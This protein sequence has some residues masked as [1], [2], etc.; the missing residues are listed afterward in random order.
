MIVESVATITPSIRLAAAYAVGL[1]P[2]AYYYVN[3]MAN[4]K[5]HITNIV[6]V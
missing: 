6:Y 4:A 5:E 3:M 1:S 2:H